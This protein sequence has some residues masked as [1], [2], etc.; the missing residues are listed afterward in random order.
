MS[1][2][3]ALDDTPTDDDLVCVSMAGG[4]FLGYRHPGTVELLD[5]VVFPLDVTARHADPFHYFEAVVAAVSEHCLVRI[6]LP[7]ANWLA[8]A[9][10]RFEPL[11]KYAWTSVTLE[12]GPG[13]DTIA[14]DYGTRSPRYQ[15]QETFDTQAIEADYRYLNPPAAPY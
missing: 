7:Y 15:V 3:L 12:R 2:L 8:H 6:E 5:S 11:R 14:F 4:R 13:V 9:P 10:K 1:R